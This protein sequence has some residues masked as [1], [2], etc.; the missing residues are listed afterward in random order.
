M[1]VKKYNPG[2]LSDQ[3]LIDSF[4]VRRA[5]F[6]SLVETLREIE[7]NSN[8]HRMVIGPRGSGKTTLLLRVAAEVR[9]DS[10]L[11]AKFFSLVL[12]EEHYE[13]STCGEFWLDCLGQLA[14]QLP[15]REDAP[16]LRLSYEDLR[17]V[18]DDRDLGNRCLAALLDFA[19]YEGK[20][21]LIIAENLNMMFEEMN[22]RDAGWRLR[23]VLQTEP[24]IMLF[25][26]A[27]SRFDEI[28]HPDQ[29]LYDF[30][31]VLTL[32]RLSTRECANLWSRVSG[33]KTLDREIRSIEILTG[34]NPRLVAIVARFGGGLSFRALMDEIL[35]LVDDHT[36]YFKSHLES[37][38]AQERRVYLALAALWKPAT[39]KEIAARARLTTSHC[40]AHIKRLMRRGAVEERGGTARRKVYYVTE[41]MYNIYYLLRKRGGP[42]EVISALIRFMAA[43]YSADE[44]ISLGANI[45]QEAMSSKAEEKTLAVDAV[46]MLVEA[47]PGHQT[48]FM[49]RLPDEFV[50]QV[51]RTEIL[52]YA[53]GW[54]GL[55]SLVGCLGALYSAHKFG[56]A[57][58]TCEEIVARFGSSD[59]PSVIERV[60][61][62]R[63]NKG[64]IL[65]EL[66]RMEDA[67]RVFDD[68]VKYSARHNGS[69]N[70][71]D[72]WA[73]ALTNKGLA[74][75][76]LGRAEEA[77]EAFDEVVARFGRSD[78]PDI[79]EK[80]SRAAFN[81]G[82]AL[83][84]LG[85][86]EDALR[87]YSEAVELIDRSVASGVVEG[88]FKACVNKAG[89]Q[90]VLGRLD[91]SLETYEDALKLL[92][93]HEA[94]SKREYEA[95]VFLNRAESLRRLNRASEALDA[96]NEALCLV[97]SE[98]ANA[99]ET[100]LTAETLFEKAVVLEGMGRYD[101]A[102]DSYSDLIARFIESEV[103]AV[104]GLALSAVI[105]KTLRL[106]VL[107][108]ID[109]ALNTYEAL[110]QYCWDGQPQSIVDLFE[111]AALNKAALGIKTGDH[112]TAIAT[113][114]H[115][116]D[117]F[118][119]GLPKNR[120]RALWIRSEAR[121]KDGDVAGSEAD[122]SA[123]LRD[124]PGSGAPLQ[125]AISQV[126]L[127]A[128][129]LGSAR[130][131]NLVDGSPSAG[132]LAPLVA[133]LN[134][135]LGREPG[136]SLEVFEIAHDIRNDLKRVRD[137]YDLAHVNNPHRIHS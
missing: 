123:A 87:T 130:V 113:A 8:V 103:T 24:R 36:E 11:S 127:F 73:A 18:R 71:D 136:V 68:I 94:I 96:C 12:S 27:T 60:A 64:A 1:S 116:L 23:K 125:S 117:R 79:L 135:D 82:K 56:E 2:F 57:I 22:D 29:A 46:A 48:R 32:C 131:L 128:A 132:L 106:D 80:V 13:V 115:V 90:A 69:G 78:L 67:I 20:R 89:V 134:M 52:K 110:E 55:P 59:L 21:L 120:V 95:R 85:R 86:H 17:Q 74:L 83:S 66:G 43:Y 37:L 121:Y 122:I 137:R 53:E 47:L 112:R 92:A 10:N 34:G 16:D 70:T 15:S 91:E 65:A 26:S 45:A 118:P 107:G 63:L 126:V 4:C 3:E 114:T 76:N 49:E 39:S 51:G 41:R 109:E 100:E 9:Q 75:A 105:N 19:D 124:L 88:A 54:T 44:L 98:G 108:R 104:F 72:L 62:A 133:A 84:K 25:A 111:K 77:V 102:L 35:D 7:G 6:E 97:D 31:D 119:A 81:K 129:R 40:S 33:K 101:E 30:F 99:K 42:S 28:D 58:E 38:P 93:V 5:E 50:K 61:E 14:E